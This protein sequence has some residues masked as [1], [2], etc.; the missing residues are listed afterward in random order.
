M[1]KLFLVLAIS[2]AFVACNN[3]ADTTTTT[4]DSTMMQTPAPSAELA[5]DSTVAPMDSTMAPVVVD[6][7]A[8]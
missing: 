5:P 3:A 2:A 8:K 6:S 1:K 7:T 4:T